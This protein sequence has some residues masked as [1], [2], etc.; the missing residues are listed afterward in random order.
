LQHPYECK[1][2]FLSL[3]DY[4]NCPY[5]VILRVIHYHLTP[6]SKLWT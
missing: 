4:S 6:L 1:R 2:L 5:K 3:K